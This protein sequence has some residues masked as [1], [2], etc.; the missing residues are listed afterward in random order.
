[1][2]T[3]II[4]IQLKFRSFLGIVA[5]TPKVHAPTKESAILFRVALVVDCKRPL[6]KRMFTPT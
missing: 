5:F 3:C 6:A 2:L 1:M 4:D